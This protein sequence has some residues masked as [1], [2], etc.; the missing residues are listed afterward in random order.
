MWRLAIFMIYGAFVLVGISACTYA[1]S[2][3][4]YPDYY[5]PIK[6]KSGKCAD[7][8]GKYESSNVYLAEALKMYG[9]ISAIEIHSDAN[10]LRVIAFSDGD[11]I[12]KTLSRENSDYKCQ[13]DGIIL[14]DTDL[15]SS[16]EIGIRKRI[17]V[18]YPATDGSLI[19]WYGEI[20]RGAALLAPLPPIT[21]SDNM[22]Y[23]YRFKPVY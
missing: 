14:L 19:M 2:H 15:P 10:T 20:A 17:V 8:S 12:R 16:N 9:D 7:I 23:W 18:V 21:F 3:D 13:E 6:A 22:G 4:T 1:P 5:P 11:Q